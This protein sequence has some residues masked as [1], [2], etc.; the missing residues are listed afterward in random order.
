MSES[1]LVTR[2]MSWDE[3]EALGDEVRGEYID[4]E[5]VVSPMPSQLH[6]LACKRMIVQLGAVVP[7]GYRVIGGWGWKSGRDE[8]GPDVMVY[9]VTSENTRFTGIPALAVEV[10]SSNRGY[11]LI[12]KSAKYSAAGLPHYWVIDPREHAIE[13]YRLDEGIFHQTARLT[14]GHAE[15]SLGIATVV[16]DIDA[17]LAE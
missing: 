15:L 11:D 10:L 4:G 7:D 5:L 2:P 6:Q 14:A 17:V 1:A 16:I 12:M 9:P 8:F 3:Y 13:T